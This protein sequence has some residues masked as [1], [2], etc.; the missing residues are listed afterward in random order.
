M[1]DSLENRKRLL[2]KAIRRKRARIVFFLGDDGGVMVYLKGNTVVRRL[3]AADSDP[4][5]TR[6]MTQLINSDPK[7]SISVLVDMIDQSYVKQSLPP[8]TKISVQKLIKRRLERDFAP[9]DIKGALPI[10]REKDGRKDWNFLLIS[11]ANSPQLIGWLDYILEFDNPFKGIYLAP[12]ESEQLVQK[13]SRET[14][15]KASSSRWQFMV[16]HNKVSGFRQVI[17]RDGRLTFT[18]LAQPVGDS[19]PEVVAGSIEQEITNTIEYLKRLSYSEDQGL[20]MYIIVAEDIKATIDKDK[21]NADHVSIL[22]PHEVAGLLQ[23]DQAAMPEDHYADVII[24]SFFAGHRKR[25]LPLSTKYSKRVQLLET[26][27]VGIKVATILVALGLLGVSALSFV[28]IPAKLADIRDLETRLGHTR[29]DFAKTKESVRLLPADLNRIIDV[30]SVHES[31][32]VERYDPLY[33]VRELDGLLGETVRVVDFE[34]QTPEEDGLKALLQNQ[35]TDVKMTFD[36]EFLN[37]RV[38]V[39]AIRRDAKALF[40]KIDEHFPGMTLSY[41]SLP[42]DNEKDQSFRTSFED[43]ES[44]IENEFLDGSPVIIKVTMETPKDNSAG[45]RGR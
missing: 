11:L 16:S 2:P 32:Y 3:Y 39:K 40:K 43:P 8:V 37:N 12:V 23:L 6:S 20:D 29:G 33:Y 42:G 36:V 14:L 28:G 44:L 30:I 27:A 4:D 34:W 10:G 26:T 22:T 25:V 21:V 9:E 18:R 15:G 38:R 5:S 35:Q 45:R 24:S 17:L 13:I 1:P 41:S 19:S 7:A 31:L